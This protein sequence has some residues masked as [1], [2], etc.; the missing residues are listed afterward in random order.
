MFLMEKCYVKRLL[1]AKNEKRL[2][3]NQT[4]FRFLKPLSISF[5]RIRCCILKK[6]KPSVFS[7][8]I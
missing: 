8:K 1:H 4:V 2:G 6:K 5:F 3:A 7:R